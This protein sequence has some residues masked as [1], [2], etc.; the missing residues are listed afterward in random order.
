MH[1]KLGRLFGKYTEE[2]FFEGDQSA[3]NPMRYLPTPF[4]TKFAQERSALSQYIQQEAVGTRMRRWER[5]VHDF[6]APYF[7]GTIARL[8]GQD[9]IPSEVQ[10]R[11]DL[12]TLA[13]VMNYLRALNEARED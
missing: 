9:I 3:F 5:P 1:G 13:D 2:M 12:D 8:T 4:H 11:R 10:H 7:R 6:L